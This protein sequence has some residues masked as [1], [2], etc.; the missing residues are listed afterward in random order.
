MSED[1]WPVKFPEN[2][3]EDEYQEHEIQRA[4]NLA[5]S[6]LRQ[7]TLNR[8]GGARIVANPCGMDHPGTWATHY[9]PLGRVNPAAAD[10][11]SCMCRYNC[12]CRPKQSV[13]LV[14]PASKINVVT[15]NGE[16]LPPDSY[17][18]ERGAYLIRQDG[19]QW[20]V[21]SPGF[22]VDYL[23]GHP[24]PIEGQYAAGALAAEFLLGM[25]KPDSCRLPRGVT[26]I[27]RQGVS[28]SVEAGLFPDGMTGIP[29]VD[30]FI[31]QWNPNG[32]KTRP[33]VYSPDMKRTE[34]TW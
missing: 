14:A 17:R 10:I 19:K 3:G 11:K 2:I 28:I 5:V 21:C 25:V 31:Y 27:T 16:A 30:A 24:V 12:A 6:S 29:E 15:V 7:L 8:V 20:P 18:V 4:K 9:E 1:F 23:S 22:T 13:K 33:R 32:L 34:A 26:Q